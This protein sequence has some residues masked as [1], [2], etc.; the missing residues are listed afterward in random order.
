MQLQKVP[1]IAVI[2]AVMTAVIVGEN[3]VTLS[4]LPSVWEHMNLEEV[5]DIFALIGVLV[6]VLAGTVNLINQLLRLKR[7]NP[8]KF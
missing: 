3:A 5:T 2:V 7:S 6:S 8:K 4:Q 1:T